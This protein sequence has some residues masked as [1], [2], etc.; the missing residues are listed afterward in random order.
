[1]LF[2]FFLF[3]FCSGSRVA[4]HFRNGLIGHHY[5]LVSVIKNQT[6][7]TQARFK[8]YAPFLI[9]PEHCINSLDTDRYRRFSVRQ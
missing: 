2:I 8:D 4:R 5:T 6:R 9:R 7:L 3:N 1:M